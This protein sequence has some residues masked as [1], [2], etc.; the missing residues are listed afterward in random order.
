[1]KKNN[2]KQRYYL[3]KAITRSFSWIID[4]LFCGLFLFLFFY[5]FFVFKN[6]NGFHLQ[7]ESIASWKYSVFAIVCFIFYFLY[8]NVVPLIWK[9]QTIGLK[10][11]GYA[12]INVHITQSF[13]INLIK[14]QFFLWILNGL[15]GLA[16]GITLSCLGDEKAALFMEQL[17]N[18]KDNNIPTVNLFLALWYVSTFVFIFLVIMMFIRNKRQAIHDI[19]SSTVTIDLKSKSDDPNRSHNTKK[20]IS[21]KNYSLPGEIKPDSFEEI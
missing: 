17:L 5:L 12:I 14:R 11:V 7:Y 2:D 9:G 1:M 3:G 4:F 20:I 10:I 21:S 13:W 19:Y 8:F 18:I 15:I 16:L 6:P